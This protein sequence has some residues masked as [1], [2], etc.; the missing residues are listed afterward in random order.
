MEIIIFNEK[1]LTSAGKSPGLPLCTNVAV[2]LSNG[3][4]GHFPIPN[5]IPGTNS[6]RGKCVRFACD[7]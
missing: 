4:Y 2:E 3:S 6:D 1:G 7:R 5:P